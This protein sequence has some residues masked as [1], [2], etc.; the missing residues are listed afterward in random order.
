M[1][2]TN[3][4]KYIQFPLFVL[5]NM[6][7]DFDKTLEYIMAYGVYH[8]SM[9]HG[10]TDDIDMRVG[11]NYLDL[12]QETDEV[13][14]KWKLDAIKIDERY[15]EIKTYKGENYPMPNVKVQLLK[16]LSK[17]TKTPK[18]LDE[19]L[20]YLSIQ[21]LLGKKKWIKTN[22]KHVIA[23]MMGY[24]SIKEVEQI[25]VDN[26]KPHLIEL[27]HRYTNPKGEISKARMQTFFRKLMNNWR[28]L[29]GVDY[30]RG[31][32]ISMQDK[33]TVDELAKRIASDKNNNKA[34]RIEQE[35]KDALKV[36]P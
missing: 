22:N 1:K 8:K 3:N 18:Q 4:Y 15:K 17:E 7:Q 35:L 19:F 34:K 36:N 32:Y 25:G 11:L 26:L 16:E 23:R 28:V 27:Y 20:G 9:E 5:R 10:R 30:T 6:H 24:A 21:S 31:F 13:L 12:P 29:K 2:A 33:M 14:F